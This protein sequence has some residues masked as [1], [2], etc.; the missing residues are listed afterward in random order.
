MKKTSDNFTTEQES[1]WAGSFGDDYTSRNSEKKWIASNTAFFSRI[2]S[3]T[4]GINNVLELGANRGLNLQ[5][6]KTL[7]P[8]ASF[9]AVEINHVA[10]L[11][12]KNL[13]FVNVF[14]ESISAF[15]PPQSYD[16]VL[17]KGVL[18]HINPEQ[19]DKVYSVIAKSAGRYI[20]IA[21]YYNP[22]PTTIDYRGYADRLF[23][24]DFAGE[25][26]DKYCDL[27]LVDYGFAWHRDPS[28]P[29]DD[30][31]WFLLENLSIPKSH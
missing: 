9:N 27:K 18:I 2:L 12:L 28:F 13:K 21:E 25:L 10:A 5:A 17:I 16:L 15:A 8:E 30:L 20:C 23:K 7:L 4:K 22:T 1:F 11:K 31:T 29:Q 19:L 26:M 6:L 14:H 24:R 3:R